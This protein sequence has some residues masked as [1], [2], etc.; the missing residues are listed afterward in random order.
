MSLS[1]ASPSSASPAWPPK[2]A[3]SSTAPSGDAAGKLLMHK[4]AGQQRVPLESLAVDRGNDKAKAAWDAQASRLLGREGQG[5]YDGRR[6]LLGQQAG[7][8]APLLSGCSKARVTCGGVARTTASKRSVPAAVVSRQPP[9]SAS[10]WSTGSC[11]THR[12][13]RQAQNHAIDQ[14]LQP[15]GETGKDG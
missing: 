14:G 5:H 15:A 3:R 13:G 6:G 2:K 8:A 10:I 9:P 11:T 12:S 4:G 1:S 7:H